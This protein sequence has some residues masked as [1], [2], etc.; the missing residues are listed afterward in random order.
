MVG[1]LLQTE[2]DTLRTVSYTA[3]ASSSELTASV[4]P[5]TAYALKKRVHQATKCKQIQN[6]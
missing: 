4:V 5:R 6:D 2:L 3:Y 1:Q